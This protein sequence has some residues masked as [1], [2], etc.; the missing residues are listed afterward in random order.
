MR[1]I[2]AGRHLTGI[3]Q[4]HLYTRTRDFADEFAAA[5]SGLDSLIMLPIYPARELP[6]EGVSS[7]M[8]LDKVTIADKTLVEK[9][10]LMDTI[11]NRKIDCLVTFGAGDID[12]FI[13]QIEDYLKNV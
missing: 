10:Q 4:P 11:K 1:E 12:R 5:L 3:F 2:F 8:I 9:Q 6:I 7:G 13:P